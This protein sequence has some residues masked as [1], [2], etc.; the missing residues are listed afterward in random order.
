MTHW[1]GR[2]SIHAL[3]AKQAGPQAVTQLT[4]RSPQGN[5]Q[6]I[7]ASFQTTAPAMVLP[8]AGPRRISGSPAPTVP[9]NHRWD[10]FSLG[11]LLVGLLTPSR[12]GRPAECMVLQLTKG[13]NADL[14]PSLQYTTPNPCTLNTLILLH[15]FY[16]SSKHTFSKLT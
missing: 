4:H 11:L 12:T 13:C 16:F 14:A 1:S 5:P 6:G 8:I 3:P 2:A 7:L 9:V 15:I 10:F